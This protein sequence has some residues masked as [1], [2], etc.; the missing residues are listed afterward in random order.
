MISSSIFSRISVSIVG[1]ISVA[2]LSF[3]TSIF[4]ANIFNSSEFGLYQYMLSLGQSIILIAGLNLGNAY[5]TYISKSEYQ[6]S[7][8]LVFAAVQTVIALFAIFFVCLFLREYL[9]DSLSLPFIFICLVG[10][11]VFF[12]LRQQTIY[13]L[14]SQRKNIFLQSLLVAA[15]LINFLILFILSKNISVKV[16]D[17]FLIMAAV[18]FL[19]WGISLFFSRFISRD[20]GV[21]TN[22]SNEIILYKSYIK[23]LVVSLVI[24]QISIIFDRWILQVNSGS[25]EQ[26]FFGIAIR[27]ATITTIVSSSIVNIFWKEISSL[28][29]DGRRDDALALL[30]I[31]YER[32]SV[33]VFFGCLYIFINAERILLLT[34]GTDYADAIFALKIMAFYPL[35]QTSVHLLSTFLYS[36]TS[37]YVIGKTSIIVAILGVFLIWLLF[38]VDTGLPG[39]VILSYKY[40]FESLL[41]TLIL[42]KALKCLGKFFALRIYLLLFPGLVVINLGFEHWLA[43]F[44]LE[45]LLHLFL[46]GLFMGLTYLL[47]L[48]VKFRV[49]LHEI[50]KI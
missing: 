5:F 43:S 10:S 49:Q 26:G 39:S 12:F 13:L 30:A 8:H 23:P 25:V 29:Y 22:W 11:F 24:V 4:L 2:A 50:F 33:V 34:Y 36:E 37:T 19:F 28:L 15:S 42:S 6:L 20:K 38:S 9:F 47:I 27:I 16:S 40:I 31:W 14:E 46:I 7:Y 1:S 45:S 3:I 41:I 21:R 35:V 18:Y 17:V 44:E 32:V 48:G